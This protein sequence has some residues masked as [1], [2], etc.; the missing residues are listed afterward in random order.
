MNLGIRYEN[1]GQVAA[2]NV[3]TLASGARWPQEAIEAAVSLA[4]ELAASPE[5]SGLT[6]PEKVSKAMAAALN[7][8]RPA[9][10][11]DYTLP[12]T[13]EQPRSMTGEEWV[14]LALALAILFCAVLALTAW[15]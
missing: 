12:A 7:A 11:L 6:D 4:E 13:P 2:T 5:Y 1:A 15:R 14:L 9:A 10:P 3:R 8:H